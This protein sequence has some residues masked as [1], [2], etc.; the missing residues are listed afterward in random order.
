M[1]NL[2]A[3]VKFAQFIYKTNVILHNCQMEEEEM[4]VN[5]V[6]SS[7]GRFGGGES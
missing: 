1:L 5:I 2:V 3:F 6:T 4:S 7:L